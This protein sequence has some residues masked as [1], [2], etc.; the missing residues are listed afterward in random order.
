MP[1][2]SGTVCG[3]PSSAS[4]SSGGGAGCGGDGGDGIEGTWKLTETR[5][6]GKGF[7]KDLSDVVEVWRLG[8]LET[9]RRAAAGTRDRWAAGDGRIGGL[10][11]L[12]RD[13]ILRRIKRAEKGSDGHSGA[14]VYHTVTSAQVSGCEDVDPTSF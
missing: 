5:S 2:T 13:E 9:K 3:T 11:A 1:W 10:R 4:R 12:A 6:G 7:A 8:A 14:K